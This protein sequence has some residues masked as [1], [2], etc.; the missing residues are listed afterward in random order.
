MVEYLLCMQ[1]GVGSIPI[2]STIVKFIVYC[3][4]V[5]NTFR[6]LLIIIRVTNIIK[7]LSTMKN[8]F[9]FG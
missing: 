1:R 6:F 5:E 2:V 7:I 3:Y 9:I 8:Q 4:K